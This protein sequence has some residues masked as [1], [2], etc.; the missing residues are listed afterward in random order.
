MAIGLKASILDRQ[1]M[2]APPS[3]LSRLGFVL[4]SLGY[5]MN[6][7]ISEKPPTYTREMPQP[8]QPSSSQ[9]HTIPSQ[10]VGQPIRI[11]V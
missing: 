3:P 7:W 5:H 4:Y 6:K 10:S 9:S 11:R 8:K 2:T 1:Q